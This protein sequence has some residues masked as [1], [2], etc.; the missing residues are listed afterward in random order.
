MA[1]D[2]LGCRS[3]GQPRR[4]PPPSGAADSAPES[5]PRGKP[6]LRGDR[7][8]AQRVDGGGRRGRGEG[9]KAE[10]RERWGKAPRRRLRRRRRAAPVRRRGSQAGGGHRRIE[11][12]R[13]LAVVRE[14]R[15]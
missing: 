6:T 14:M 13:G 10:G 9:G 4:L 11:R 15:S 1:R 3:G 5:A 8:R 12:A 2:R 7:V